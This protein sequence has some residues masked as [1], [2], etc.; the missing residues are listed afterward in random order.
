M[1]DADYTLKNCPPR[2]LFKL[3]QIDADVQKRQKMGG[4]ARTLQ[5]IV[6]AVGNAFA[7]AVGKGVNEDKFREGLENVHNQAKPKQELSRF[8]KFKAEFSST[9]SKRGLFRGI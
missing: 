4:V 9:K 1:V 7:R 6:N 8:G 5:D 2:L 3:M